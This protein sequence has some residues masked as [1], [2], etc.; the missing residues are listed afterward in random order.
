[1]YFLFFAWLPI[2]NHLMKKGAGWRE[3][4]FYYNEGSLNIKMLS[5]I[6]NHQSIFPDKKCTDRTLTCSFSNWIIFLKKSTENGRL[7]CKLKRK[8]LL[9]FTMTKNLLYLMNI[10]TYGQCL[11]NMWFNKDLAIIQCKNW[12][13]P[14]VILNAFNLQWLTL[15]HQ[16]LSY[17]VFF[18]FFSF[19]LSEF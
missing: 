15:H 16:I 6:N 14:P 9:S 5:E 7:S 8:R 19:S 12:T 1:M 10:N 2:L 3:C 4:V 13:G 18:P 17:P 11:H